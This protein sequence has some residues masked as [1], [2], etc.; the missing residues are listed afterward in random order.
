[1]RPFLIIISVLLFTEGN[2][3]TG[4]LPL[5]LHFE[6]IDEKDGLSNNVVNTV[7]CDSRGFM[8]FGTDDGVNMFDGTSFT[9][10][11]HSIIDTFS[12]SGNF[13]HSIAEDNQNHIWLGMQCTGLSELNPFNK[14]CRHFYGS[15]N[16]GSLESSCDNYIVFDSGNR[17][18]VCNDG[19]LSLLNDDEKTFTNFHPFAPGENNMVYKMAILKNTIWLSHRFGI[20]S[21]NIK[22]KKFTSFDKLVDSNICGKILTTEDGDLLVCTW[23]NGLY[24]INPSTLHSVRFLAGKIVNDAAV[25]MVAGHRQLWVATTSG[26]YIAEL[27]K[28]ISS[29]N[30]KSFVEYKHDPSDAA[31][32]STD[33]INCIYYDQQKGSS[34]WLG[35]P[36]G[37][38]KLNPRY[39]Q[40]SVN[41]ITKNKKPF[42][43]STLYNI[44]SEKDPERNTIYWLSYWHGSGLVQTDSLF[45]VK[46]QLLISDKNGTVPKIISD[47][48]RG[49]DGWLW[50]ATWDGLW[51]YDDKHGKLIKAFRKEG[52]GKI[53]LS[54]NRLDYLLQDEKG[55]M[56]IGTY[57]QGVNLVDFS[58]SSVHVFYADG[59]PSSITDNR[60]D[61]IFED[62]KNRIWIAANDLNLYR[63]STNDFEAFATKMG[64]A[65]S[66]PGHV[67]A[68]M[69]DSNSKIWVATDGGLSWI[70]EKN[71]SFHTYTT[72]D[73]LPSEICQAMTEDRNG[74]IWVNTYG[75][76][77]SIN[78]NNF[79]IRSYTKNDGLPTNQLGNI[80]DTSSDGKI[81]FSLDEGNSPLVSFDPSS[82][83]TH[84]MEAPFQ[85][86]SVSILG[87]EQPFAKAIEASG[88]L[89]LSYK[90]NLFTV[91]FKALDYQNAAN[92]R[93]QCMLEGFNK[94]WIDIGRRTSITYT[95]LDGGTY[96]LKVKATNS[97]GEWLEKELSLTIIVHPPFWKTWWFYIVCFITAAFLVWFIFTRRVKA[98]RRQEE[99]KTAVANEM[100]DLKMKALKAQM[101]PHF[102]FNALSSIQESILTGKTEAAAKYLGKFSKLIRMVLEF[103]DKKY[104]TLQ[105]E[106][107][108]IGL[109]LELESFR[110][111]NFHFFVLVDETMDKE[112]IKI[113]PMLVQPFVENAVKHGLSHKPDDKSVKII[114]SG[115]EEIFLKVTVDDNGIGRKQ[116]AEI[117]AAR[118]FSHQ[119]MGMKITED[120]L[121]IMQQKN[122]SLL[123]VNDKLKADGTSAGT[124][125]TLL[126]PIETNA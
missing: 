111:D 91:T 92:I 28:E 98:I 108:Y 114:F 34:V 81:F 24:I 113:P 106:E 51:C 72:G 124:T 77:C 11:R 103:S 9:V 99:N 73:G 102:V 76:L 62:N 125:V 8:W 14:K 52:P 122:A 20:K 4:A 119:S 63:E 116:S 89:N 54:T 104:I 15:V 88:P 117:N 27:N 45:R 101:N 13:V 60:S 12:V 19:A 93:Y 86:V 65:S 59:K 112:F 82:L 66:L 120:R 5:P 96:I 1:M 3:Q 123:S 41:A 109:Y 121:Q 94:T 97:S 40:F 68:V 55:R 18:W 107:Q 23:L 35:T 29:L 69:Q 39:L 70:D 74:N 80:I 33:I 83:L 75:G 53:H 16:Q 22:T 25:V 38:D 57:G 87:V 67:N 17:M 115:E 84:K 6:H 95:N 90:Q 56:W 46:K 64:D 10:F 85:F 105:Q 31:S 71:K 79:I 44:F 36:D 110:F 49:R 47:A 21:F 32:L 37:I 100:A 58:D 48:V 42:N 30:D 78:I 126:I 2:P 61:F 26:L 50:L 7:F 43:T 118:T